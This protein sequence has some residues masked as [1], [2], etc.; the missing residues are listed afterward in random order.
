MY[1]DPI[2]MMEMNE[3]P[4]PMRDDYMEEFNEV[5]GMI[6]DSIESEKEDEMFYDYLISIAPTEDEKQI[7]GSIRNDE[8]KHNMYFRQIYEDLTGETIE[9]IDNITFEEPASYVDGIKTAL[10]DELRAV[11]KYRP[12]RELMPNRYYRDVL[13]EII[14]DELKH[15]AK[16]NYLFA[17]NQ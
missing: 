10:F 15:A 4:M 13:F 1:L 12:I 14:T 5:L 7:I 17:L 8:K 3:E 11:E 6:R 2:N 16:Y 9:P